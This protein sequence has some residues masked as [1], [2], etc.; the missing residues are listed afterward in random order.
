MDAGGSADRVAAVRSML[1]QL[2]GAREGAEAVYVGDE[3]AAFKSRA[4][5]VCTGDATGPLGEAA[6][7]WTGEADPPTVDAATMAIARGLAAAAVK[8]ALERRPTLRVQVEHDGGEPGVATLAAMLAVDAPRTLDVAAARLLAGKRES[9]GWLSDAVGALAAFAPAADAKDGLAIPVGRAKMT[10]VAL[11]PTGAASSFRLDTHPWRIDRDGSGTA[12]GMKRDGAPVATPMLATVHAV[13]TEGTSW[14]GAGMIFARLGG[15]PRVAIAAG[16]RVRVVGTSVADAVS[17][18]APADDLT[19]EADLRVDDA[20]GGVAVRAVPGTRGMHG[21][22][23]L[24]VPG[25][26]PRAAL[27]VGDGYG[28]ETAVAP[29]VDLPP[30]GSV[31]VALAVRGNRVDATVGG[32]TLSVTVPADYAHGD[33]ALRA[34]PGATVEASH[35]SLLA[36]G[37]KR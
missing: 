35:W 33:V 22:S 15:T 31:H 19:L 25:A 12:S 6:S 2:P 18:P 7:P 28:D 26:K 17:T 21:V 37:K 16:P 9:A 23:L 32:T 30:G 10:H 27:L 36:P 24:V 5:V 1:N 14:N 20:P 29:A 3:H 8:H 11:E 34:Y 13:A 4:P